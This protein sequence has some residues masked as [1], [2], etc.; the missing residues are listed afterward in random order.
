MTNCSD[1][2]RRPTGT[3][4]QSYLVLTQMDHENEVPVVRGVFTSIDDLKDMAEDYLEY[5]TF[6]P[7]EHELIIVPLIEHHGE[8]PDMNIYATSEILVETEDGEH[9]HSGLFVWDSAKKR[10][11]QAP[12]KL[13][14]CATPDGDE[15]WFIIARSGYEATLEY[16]SLEGYDV[17]DVTAD[18]V[19]NL[20]AECQTDEREAVGWPTDEVLVA[21][22][23]RF[24]R[25]Q[26]P[27]VVEL[28]G[29]TFTEGMLE[30]EIE[31]ARAALAVEAN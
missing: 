3:P 26:T 20:P 21:C 29:R 8:D 4:E 15:D 16:A 25:R 5:G 12:L 18:F 19:M 28:S 24:L 30:G 2:R 23:A 31:K 13:Y 10:Q 14:W 11:A 17:S 1:S 7:D 27:R 9:R 22:G 6:S